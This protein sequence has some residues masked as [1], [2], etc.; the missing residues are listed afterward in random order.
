METL[1][2]ICN[3]RTVKT[4]DGSINLSLNLFVLICLNPSYT[5]NFLL[6]PTIFIYNKSS[7]LVYFIFLILLP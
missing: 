5:E 4:I 6:G 1:K 7:C 3:L 2:A